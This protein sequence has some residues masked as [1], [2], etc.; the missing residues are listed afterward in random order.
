M[1]CPNDNTLGVTHS[2][3][4]LGFIFTPLEFCACVKMQIDKNINKVM[5]RFIEQTYNKKSLIFLG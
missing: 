3:L 4:R 1:D 2:I 5:A